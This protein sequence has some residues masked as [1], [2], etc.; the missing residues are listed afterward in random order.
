MTHAQASALHQFL[1]S[2]LCAVVPG[3]QNVR[4]DRATGHVSA[5]DSLGWRVVGT[6]AD[7][8]SIARALGRI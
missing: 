6:V 3:L 8:T 1:L 7:F 2:W 4:I 5:R